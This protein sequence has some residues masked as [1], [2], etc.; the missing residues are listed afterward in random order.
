MPAKKLSLDVA[1]LPAIE[2]GRR[3]TIPQALQYLGVCRATFY[4]ALDAGEIRTITTCGRRF[5]GGQELL[6]HMGVPASSH[7]E[8]LSA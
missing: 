5:V 7:S 3:Y 8:A 6:R 2:A 4:K 1:P